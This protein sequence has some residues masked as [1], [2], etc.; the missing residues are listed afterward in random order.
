MVVLSD[1]EPIVRRLIGDNLKTASDIFVYRTSNVFTLTEP[2]F[3]TTGIQVF[4]NDVVT[5]G[6]TFDSTTGRLTVT[7]PL[8]N[9]D[10]V[11][12]RYS[13]YPN[14]SPSEIESYIQAA[15]THFVINKYNEYSVG[16]DANIYPEPSPP[17]I[18]LIAMITSVL[19]ED[20]V[21]AF[22]LPDVTISFNKDLP[23][24]EKVAM[25]INAFKHARIGAFA[26]E[27]DTISLVN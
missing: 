21:S 9:G 7:D 24:D 4:I 26:V 22:R 6:F 16:S 14:Y 5:V 1:I 12:I 10:V 17:E 25:I 13:A 8:V 15:L 23:R 27:I 18:N 3:V 20:S 19:I 11:E 2:H